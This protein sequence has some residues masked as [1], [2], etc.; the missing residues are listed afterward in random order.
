LSENTEINI[1]TN[2]H[3]LKE[4]KK[5]KLTSALGDTDIDASQFAVSGTSHQSSG[6]ADTHLARLL[7]SRD[8]SETLDGCITVHLFEEAGGYSRINAVNYFLVCVPKGIT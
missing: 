2:G 7:I 4:V 8:R 3:I 1:L 5:Y 6:D